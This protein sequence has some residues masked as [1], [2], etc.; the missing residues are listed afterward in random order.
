MMLIILLG[1][2]N[3]G[4]STLSNWWKFNLLPISNEKIQAIVI[5]KSLNRQFELREPL[6]VDGNIY[7]APMFRSTIYLGIHIDDNITFLTQVDYYS[8]D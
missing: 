4:P 3:S 2:M 1:V 7:M 8:I 5:L 6:I